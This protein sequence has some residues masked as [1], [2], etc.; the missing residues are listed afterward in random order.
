MCE[1][2][3][4][5]SGTEKDA[6]AVLQY[7]DQVQVLR[8]LP[9][10]DAQK[11]DNLLVWPISLVFQALPTQTT[12]C[13]GQYVYDFPKLIRVLVTLQSNIVG[14]HRIVFEENVN[15]TPLFVGGYLR[16][17]LGLLVEPYRD[18]V[19]YVVRHGKGMAYTRAP[20][21]CPALLLAIYQFIQVAVYPPQE[22]SAVA[23]G[24][25]TR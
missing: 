20:F 17:D 16:Y 3:R 6:F 24:T 25:A 12:S 14:I 10:D 8:L 4:L 7:T 9:R 18:F 11:S 1:K 21:L 15:N 22:N 19:R 13:C 23:K 5:E 2:D